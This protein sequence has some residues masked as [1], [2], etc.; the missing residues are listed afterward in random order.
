MWYRLTNVPNTLEM[1]N[2]LVVK[3]VISYPIKLMAFAILK[4]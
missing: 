3:W 1:V 4:M 2:V